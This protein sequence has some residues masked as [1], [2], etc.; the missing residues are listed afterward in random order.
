MLNSENKNEMLV[1]NFAIISGTLLSG[2]WI[3]KGHD[4]YYGN[5]DNKRMLLGALK[6]LQKHKSEALEIFT[7]SYQVYA[8]LAH[9]S[10]SDF[11]AT[12]SDILL[13]YSGFSKMPNKLDIKT[14]QILQEV[15]ALIKKSTTEDI[16]SLNKLISLFHPSDFALSKDD[17]TEIINL[18]EER[19]EIISRL[20]KIDSIFSQLEELGLNEFHKL[21]VLNQESGT[22]SLG[23]L[24]HTENHI[25][26]ISSSDDDEALQEGGLYVQNN[27][28]IEVNG[29][30]AFPEAL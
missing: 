20:V 18:S 17:L 4:L 9:M 16:D 6:Y 5:Y 21:L 25:K 24:M 29:E 1:R 3:L 12:E 11:V 19:E 15:H 30:V 26:S 10:G 14:K 7:K 28:N 2:Y 23:D 22:D 8:P 27:N 13:F